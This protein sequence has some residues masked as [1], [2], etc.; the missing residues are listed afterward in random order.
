MGSGV[1]GPKEYRSLIQKLEEFHEQTEKLMDERGARLGV[2]QHE[3]LSSLLG[4]LTS[5]QIVVGQFGWWEGANAA[6]VVRYAAFMEETR[7]LMVQSLMKPVREEV[8]NGGK[9]KKRGRAAQLYETAMENVLYKRKRINKPW[10]QIDLVSISSSDAK[11]DA[12]N[13]STIPIDS[14]DN[15]AG[16]LSSSSDDDKEN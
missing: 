7:L 1:H 10:G 5:L 12:P 16:G 2:E 11:D 13:G 8:K 4:M 14:G 3:G 9:E 15:D 6:F